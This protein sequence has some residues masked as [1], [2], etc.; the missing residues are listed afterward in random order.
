MTK[1]AIISL[2]CARNDV[3]SEELAAKL[4]ADGLILEKDPEKADAV[5]VNTC[6]FIEQ[7]KKDS[8]DTLLE[9]SELK[10]SS[11]VKAVVAVGCMAERYGAELEQALP[12]ADAILGFDDYPLIAQKVMRILNGEKLAAP[13]VQDRRLLLPV[14]PVER[15]QA[16]KFSHRTRLESGPSSPLKIASGCDRRCT[17]CA[18]PRFRGS[19]ISRSIEEIVDEAHWLASE[20]VK[21]VFL[22]SEN[23]T[24]YGKDLGDLRSLEKLI[25]ELAKINDLD[26]IRLSYL[27]PAEMRPSLTKSI[28]ETEKVVPYFDLSFQ[29]AS[30]SLLRRMKRFGSKDEFLS[31][32]SEIR[33]A[34]PAAGIRSNFIV[35]FVQESESEF[36]ELLS[37][38][39]LAEL[40]SIGIFEYANEDN[41][42]AF[43]YEGQISSGEKRQRFNELKSLAEELIDQRA[44]SR[45][46]EQTQ[47]LIEGLEDGQYFGRS[48]HQGPDVD[49]TTHLP[50]GKYKVGQLINIS[51]TSNLGADLI[52]EE[53]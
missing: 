36:E 48:R 18:I 47:V 51:V 31:M 15:K 20:G 37:F 9:A 17:F 11:G 30:N 24:S 21:E 23:T 3:D 43:D 29:H 27:Q 40:D 22:V 46:G 2:G 26:W 10:N 42:A 6:G 41:T 28:L 38:I 50:M 25:E 52:G 16:A 12:E 32:I 33:T 8:I 35:G 5:L 1:V 39:E 49:G 44:A 14:T 13:K 34:N 4:K 7:A 45:V 53:L 19:Y